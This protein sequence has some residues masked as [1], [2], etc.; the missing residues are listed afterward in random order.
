[1]TLR[2]CS[3]CNRQAAVAQLHHFSPQQT[4]WSRIRLSVQVL[5]RFNEWRAKEVDYGFNSGRY[6][7]ACEH[8]NFDGPCDERVAVELKYTNVLTCFRSSGLE[9]ARKCSLLSARFM[10]GG[11]RTPHGSGQLCPS[12]RQRSIFAGFGTIDDR[13]LGRNRDFGGQ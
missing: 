7:H 2:H 5:W 1:M 6:L 12:A 3:R 8:W 13:P 4:S 11:K 9:P 10:R